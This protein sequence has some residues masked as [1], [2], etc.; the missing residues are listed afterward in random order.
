MPSTRYKP[1][2]PISVNKPLPADTRGEAPS[3]VRIKP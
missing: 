2:K 1:M 3:A